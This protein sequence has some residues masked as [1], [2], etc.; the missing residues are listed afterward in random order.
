M[1]PTRRQLLCAA[2]LALPLAACGIGGG[3]APRR[4]TLEPL[5]P[6]PLDPADP[7]GSVAI[8]LPRSLQNLDSARIAYS[9]DRR[10]TQ[11][12]AGADWID[13][14][15][16][17]LRMLMIRSFQNRTRTLATAADLPGPGGEFLLSSI[18]QDFQ[19]EKHG[20][21]VTAHVTIVVTLA[22]MA[23]RQDSR[24]KML[25][26]RQAASDDRIESVVAAFD[27]ATQSVLA[28]LLAFVSEGMR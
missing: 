12:Y 1:S 10:E 6:A 16:E 18:L 20:A 4:F 7:P 21:E 13:R 3:N 14:P 8:A 22:R 24:T 15:P 19:A 9:P 26:A 27:G 25:E 2:G 17:M 23:R 11:Y 28:D 5:P